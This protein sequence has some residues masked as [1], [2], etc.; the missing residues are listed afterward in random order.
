M[1]IKRLL[2]ITIVLY[3][4]MGCRTPEPTYSL[5]CLPSDTN[6]IEQATIEIGAEL[7]TYVNWQH[8]L[9]PI[10]HQ[11]SAA[12]CVGFATAYYGMHG[13]S[14]SY[15]YNQR[16]VG[17]GGCARDNGM[18]LR[19]A[20]DI[21]SEGALPI[22]D[23]PYTPS[24]LCTIPGPGLMETAT[25]Y[26][27]DGY[28]MLFVG[29][30]EDVGA[31][32][33]ALFAGYPVVLAVAVYSPTFYAPDSAGRIGPHQ[34]GDTYY[35]GHALCAYGYGPDGLYVV[36]SWGT[37]W[38]VG[39]RAVLAWSMAAL[40]VWEAWVLYEPW[41]DTETTPTIPLPP[42]RPSLT[43]TA[44]IEATSTPVS[45]ATPTY[46]PTP[47]LLMPPVMPSN[48]PTQ[49]PTIT[50]TPGPSATPAKLYRVEFFIS[51]Q[52]EDG[53]WQLIASR[54]FVDCTEG[55]IGG[56]M[57]MTVESGREVYQ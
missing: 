44:T 2:V 22:A 37:G 13:M 50:N 36:N 54:V 7:P 4:L 18:T 16:T 11:G 25:E 43:P 33:A 8:R 38:G 23:W 55:A 6:G 57:G 42:E 51:E 40:D 1:I 30:T 45:S 24:D 21:L 52:L 3:A 28:G 39:G 32:K 26:A 48:T 9:P 34:D 31:I 29:G 5:G 27:L 15:V 35:G 10:M 19:N 56:Y 14:P 46:K 49:S 47:T 53:T 17:T 20:F 41:E 12:T